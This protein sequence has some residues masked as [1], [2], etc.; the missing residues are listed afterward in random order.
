MAEALLPLNVPWAT[1]AAMFRERCA[2]TEVLLPLKV[3]WARLCNTRGIA[4]EGRDLH[5]VC[6]GILCVCRHREAD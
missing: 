4:A 1:V 3:T 2:M 6:D 5:D